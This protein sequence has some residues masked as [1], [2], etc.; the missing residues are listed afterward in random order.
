MYK[1]SLLVDSHKVKSV[2]EKIAKLN[3]FGKNRKFWIFKYFISL[4]S[5]KLDFERKIHLNKT[6]NIVMSDYNSKKNEKNEKML[7]IY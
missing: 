7:R 5:V 6:L 4:Y 3:T 2:C 1:I